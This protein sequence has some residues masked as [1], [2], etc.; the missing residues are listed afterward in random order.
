MHL[1]KLA[2]A[3]LA[4]ALATT[5]VAETDPRLGAYYEDQARADRH[6]QQEEWVPAYRAYRDLARKG[7]NFSQYRLAWL[8]LTGNGTGQD[9]VEAYGWARLAAQ[10]DNEQL[11]EFRDK[12]YAAVPESERGEADEKA[13][14]YMERYGNLALAQQSRAKVKRR[15]RSCTG[16][17]LGS[18]CEQVYVASMPNYIGIAPGGANGGE[19]SG[20]A[21]DSAGNAGELGSAGAE[22]RDVEYYLG[23]RA[24][25]KQL[26]RYLE[27]NTGTVELGEF[28]LI[29]DAPAPSEVP[30]DSD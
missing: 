21:A 4:V 26:D 29:D 6:F 18:S 28:E 5:A 9:L 16:S 20:G 7:D 12:V 17:R 22:T 15:L 8:H 13:A 25:L 10:N 2:G 30:N 23:L 19:P 24:T 14:Y 3:A 27:D 1:K 11:V